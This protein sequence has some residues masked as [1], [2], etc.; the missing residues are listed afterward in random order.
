MLA[1]AQLQCVDQSAA[2]LKLSVVSGEIDYTQFYVVDRMET[3]FAPGITFEARIIGASH[4]ITFRHDDLV[5]HEVCACVDVRERAKAHH[6]RLV[7]IGV[8]NAI[9]LCF[10]DDE[11]VLRYRFGAERSDLRR[12]LLAVRAME[13]EVAAEENVGLAFTFPHAWG[14]GSH[15]PP[16]TIVVARE[17]AKPGIFDDSF[18]AASASLLV[19]TAHLYPNENTAVLTKTLLELSP[20]ESG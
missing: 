9:D 8:C 16:K 3:Q 20:K 2:D 17:S 6:G 15:M 13:E 11:H 4:V 7:D 10:D 14:S 1:S 5:I 19:R 18:C 12:S